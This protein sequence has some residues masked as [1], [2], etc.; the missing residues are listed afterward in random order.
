MSG[1]YLLFASAGAGSAIVEAGL[2][3]SGLPYAVDEV[4]PWTEGPGRERLRAANPLLQVPALRLPDGRIMTESA[5]MLLHIADQAPE[6]GLAPPAADDARPDFLRWLVFLV[7]SLYPTFTFGDDP[8][9][10]VDGPGPAADALRR[11]SDAAREAMWRQVEAAAG[12]PWLLGGRFSALD[13]YV[14]AM[15]HW[16][17]RRAWFAAE[18]P[19]LDAI[20]T[21]ALALP[22]LQPVWRRNGFV[23]D[24]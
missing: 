21:R 17:P 24:A 9:R 5:A 1:S 19:R 18:C 11:S 13:L 20:A 4:D 7:A 15:V 2:A 16:R 3:L 6:A 10:W 14:A 23:A 8:K 22:A 12:A